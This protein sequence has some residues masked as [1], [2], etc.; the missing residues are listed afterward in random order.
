M[1]LSGK[2]G[3][4]NRLGQ[5]Q[6]KW[7]CTEVGM[8]C[9]IP[10]GFYQGE[11]KTPMCDSTNPPPKGDL[12]C[13]FFNNE[14]QGKWEKGEMNGLVQLDCSVC[15]SNMLQ[16]P[17]HKDGK[18]GIQVWNHQDYPPQT[19]LCHCTRPVRGSSQPEKGGQLK[20]LCTVAASSNLCAI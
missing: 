1:L 7:L 11:C 18:N 9:T 4:K 3:E 10:H 12:C 20:H 19:P 13:A 5:T 14:T 6:R 8:P 15:R 17:K 16:T 2:A